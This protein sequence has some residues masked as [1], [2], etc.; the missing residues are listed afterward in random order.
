MLRQGIL[1]TPAISLQTSRLFK[2][3]LWGEFPE[4][5]WAKDVSSGS[6]D[7]RLS[8]KRDSHLLRMTE[9]KAYRYHQKRTAT[10]KT[11]VFRPLT[12]KKEKAA[13]FREE[14]LWIF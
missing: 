12:P 3:K 6:F 4:T 7:A 14:P 1:P 2:T 5:A 10:H 13:L 9:G 8:R 11:K